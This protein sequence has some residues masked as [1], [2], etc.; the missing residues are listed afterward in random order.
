[1]ELPLQLP[2]GLIPACVVAQC[3][4][5]LHSNRPEP[6][7][8]P[9]KRVD[10]WR[11]PSF[12]HEAGAGGQARRR[13]R[14]D[15]AR[16]MATAPNSP[17][18][19]APLTRGV[20]LVGGFVMLLL[21]AVASRYGWHRD[22]LYFLEAGTHLAW[23]YVDQ[24]P[25]TPFVAHLAESLAP[26]NLVAFRAFPAL[27]TAGT[28]V[29]AGVVVREMG[30]SGRYQLAG[31]AAVAAGGFALGAGHLLATATLD[32][33]A[34]IVLLWITAR[35]LRTGDPRWWVPAGA[36]FGMAMLNKS[37][38]VMLAAAVATGLFGARRWDL[39]AS[40][41]LAVGVAV[42]TAIAAPYLYWQASNGW[43]QVEMGR[44]LSARLG[45]E[46]RMLLVP[47]QILFVGPAFV[48]LMGRGAGWLA[49]DANGSRYKALLWAWAAGMTLTLV[50]GGRPYYPVPLT[51]LLL[52]AG[53]VAYE[54]RGSDARDLR[55]PIL[56]NGVASLLVALPLLP[57]AMVN[58]TS[59][60]NESMAE[61]VGWP[62]LVAQ[63]AGVVDSLPEAERD[64]VVI[65]A[66]S[67]GE[68]GAID[69]FGPSHGLPPAYSAHNSYA[70]FRRPDDDTATT[71]A[72]RY[73]PEFLAQY[74]ETCQ[75]VAR[76]D[77]GHDVDNE[78]QG[79]PIL[80]CRGLRSSWAA[81]WPRLRHLS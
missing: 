67:Y 78:A 19:L 29:M 57:M 2:A 62:E 16:A 79:Q 3:A 4:H 22:E 47:L 72:V 71:V 73:H 20:W 11:H 81:T 66:A 49:G 43:P 34:W 30:G 52:L 54:R 65:L 58:I 63:V 24:P 77:N 9:P 56:I 42:A 51:V 37:L 50:T 21:L 59:R 48:G 31:A 68:A 28:V 18:I 14:R 6:P 41:W 75:Q 39:L 17:A 64:G 40:P 46:N 76:I 15:H 8:A 10:P 33:L 23:G 44:V 13:R 80:V 74:F 45:A 53:V 35:M 69:R 70:D 27:V 61:T 36:V 1:V 60:V 55:G 12:G 7:S 38:V 32:L 5:L 26:G 25:L